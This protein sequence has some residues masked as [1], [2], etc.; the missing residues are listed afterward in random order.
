MKTCVQTN[1]PKLY[2]LISYICTVGIG[3]RDKS[4]EHPFF[5]ESLQ[6]KKKE[7]IN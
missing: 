3:G 7:S 6:K 5:L 2:T 4:D 1:V